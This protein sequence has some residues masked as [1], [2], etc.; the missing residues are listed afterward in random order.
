M[1]NPIASSTTDMLTKNREENAA[2][3]QETETDM[4]VFYTRFE[5]GFKS[6]PLV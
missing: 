3:I 4:Y 1:L 5:C 6:S 2:V